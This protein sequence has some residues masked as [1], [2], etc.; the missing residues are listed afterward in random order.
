MDFD[1]PDP[2]KH[3]SPK[4]HQNSFL[5]LDKPIESC[6]GCF[7]FNLQAIQ[8]KLMLKKSKIYHILIS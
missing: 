1:T 4:S 6:K 8:V 5:S 2:S 7:E 3:P